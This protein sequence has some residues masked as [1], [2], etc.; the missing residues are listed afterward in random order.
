M[1]FL[2]LIVGASY[3]PNSG[4]NGKPLTE[5]LLRELSRKL[6]SRG[7][8]DFAQVSLGIDDAT[9]Q[10]IGQDC[11][12]ARDKIYNVLLRWKNK[13]KGTADD[14]RGHFDKAREDDV[15]VVSDDAYAIL[16]K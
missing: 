1:D 13:T 5:K 2:P 9:I 11:D 12:N 4:S 10:H 3:L 14:L 8:N 6:P 15:M 16:N 7:F